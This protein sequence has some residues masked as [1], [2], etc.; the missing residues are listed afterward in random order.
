MFLEPFPDQHIPI[1]LVLLNDP[2]ILPCMNNITCAL[3]V[4]TL[5][6][7]FVAVVLAKYT[8]KSILI[9]TSLSTYA[10]TSVHNFA[11]SKGSWIKIKFTA[12][13]KLFSKQ[14]YLLTSP[15]TKH[16]SASSSPRNAE[17]QTF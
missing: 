17:Y 3:L 14:L 8:A 4:D 1:S 6:V 5:V 2:L 15:L 12:I 11:K 10:N 7:S 9:N 16:S 13:T